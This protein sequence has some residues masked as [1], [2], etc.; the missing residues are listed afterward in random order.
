MINYYNPN[1][2][3]NVYLTTLDSRADESLPYKTIA[4]ANSDGTVTAAKQEYEINVS[5]VTG[6]YY[7]VISVNGRET[8][9]GSATLYEMHLE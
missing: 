7:I 5:G 2:E 9:T 3:V 8:R 6:D 1:N 4:Y